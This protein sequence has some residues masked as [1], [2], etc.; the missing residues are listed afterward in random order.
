MGGKQF[1]VTLSEHDE[2]NSEKG[3][4][5]LLSG[6]ASQH[7]ILHNF[8]QLDAVGLDHCVVA[9]EGSTFVS[10]S[11]CFSLHHLTEVSYKA[12]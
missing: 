3:I 2:W 7:E 9:A 4:A 6:G 8:E 1:H 5:S 11:Q 12:L 10:A